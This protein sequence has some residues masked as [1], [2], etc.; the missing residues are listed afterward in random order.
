MQAVPP[1]E[2]AVTLHTATLDY[3]RVMAATAVTLA[4]RQILTSTAAVSLEVR[5]VELELV[6]F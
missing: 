4:L 3:Q 1:V 2:L 6:P 5:I